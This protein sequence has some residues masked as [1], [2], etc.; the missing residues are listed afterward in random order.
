MKKLNADGSIEIYK[1][2]LVACGNE[3]VLGVNYTLTFAAVLEMTSGKAVLALARIW[4]VPARHGD[5]PNA[6][7]KAMAEEGVD[8]ILYIPDG[9]EVS[10]ELLL[11]L[12]ASDRKELG[13]RLDRSLYE[14][15][16]AGRLWHQRQS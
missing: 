2:R 3:Q 6:Y 11:E 14:L 4:G 16:Q 12:G 8:I 9:M 7:V 10:A 13:L 15:K 5:V 1:A